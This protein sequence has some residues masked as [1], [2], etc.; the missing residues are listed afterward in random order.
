M[1]LDNTVNNIE[2][3]NK[4]IELETDIDNNE[5]NKHSGMNIICYILQLIIII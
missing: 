5:T 1:Q 3:D 4:E 2:L